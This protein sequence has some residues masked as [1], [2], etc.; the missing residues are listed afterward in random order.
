MKDQDT[1]QAG[2]AEL[3]T[4]QSRV[5]KL[6]MSQGQ[7]EQSLYHD[8]EQMVG[9]REQLVTDLTSDIPE[10][11]AELC[12]SQMMVKTNCENHKMCQDQAEQWL[13]PGKKLVGDKASENP[14]SR[15]ELCTDQS[16][17]ISSCENHELI[18][19]QTEQCPG[20]QQCRAEPDA[21]LCR[22]GH[23]WQNSEKSRVQ[24]EKCG[25]E[26]GPGKTEK[27]SIVITSEVR[28]RA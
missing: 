13:C 19:D 14:A 3:C 8:A 4:S 16:Q 6:E 26:N 20:G 23:S 5:E 12:T 15:A 10:S 7:A 18:A 27:A 28:E 24:A 17:T 11:Q 22:S 21:T 1:S 25:P 2:R 9:Q